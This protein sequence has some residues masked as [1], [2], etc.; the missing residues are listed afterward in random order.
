MSSCLSRPASIRDRSSS[1]LISRSSPIASSMIEC[2]RPALSA[3]GD[4]ASISEAVETIP[5]R[6]VRNSWLTLA[7][8]CD[9][10]WLARCASSF[11]ACSLLISMPA[12]SGTTVSSTRW[13][14]PEQRIAAPVRR[15]HRHQAEAEHRHRLA[16]V[17]GVAADAEAEAEDAE[18]V[19]LVP[20]R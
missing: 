11:A 8:S 3:S 4:C 13:G 7:S 20:S 12:Y 18:Q 15:Q 10:A 5:V 9:L 19:D 6:G 17:H 14:E 1:C 2:A 16:Q